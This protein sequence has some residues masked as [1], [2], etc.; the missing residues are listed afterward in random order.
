MRAEELARGIATHFK[1][2]LERYRK[3]NGA[4][5]DRIIFYRDGVGEGQLQFVHTVS[6]STSIRSRRGI[7]VFVFSLF[8]TRLPS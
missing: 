8:S 1:T 7:D 5:P 3:E 4:F 6:C 2:G